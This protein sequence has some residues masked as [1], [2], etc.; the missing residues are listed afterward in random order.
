MDICIFKPFLDTVFRGK[1]D[2]EAFMQYIV[3]GYDT[4]HYSVIDEKMV[5]EYQASS[6]CSSKTMVESV[7]EPRTVILSMLLKLLGEPET[8]SVVLSEEVAGCDEFSKRSIIADKNETT[9]DMTLKV[10]PK[11][12]FE[13]TDEFETNRNVE[14]CIRDDEK[15]IVC[16]GHEFDI[17]TYI[18]G[19]SD[20][21]FSALMTLIRGS[22]C[23]AVS[24]FNKLK[25]YYNQINR[26]Q[27]K[28]RYK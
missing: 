2:E 17:D 11:D 3:A 21:G 23:S 10:V 18:I 26:N 6:G 5:M 25:E 4:L 22:N 8:F 14:R 20:G 19:Q 16:F 13:K 12:E 7:N 9:S 15:Q 1:S 27:Y 28:N 24:S